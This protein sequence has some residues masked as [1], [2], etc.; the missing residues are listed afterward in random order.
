MTNVYSIREQKLEN[1]DAKHLDKLRAY[2][3]AYQAFP[4]MAKLC[5]VVDMT[6]TASVFALV[7]RLVEAGQLKRVDGRIAPT[8]TFLARPVECAEP[9][10]AEAVTASLEPEVV[11]L[12]DYVMPEP[13]G[14]FFVRVPDEQ[15][16]AKDIRQ[17]DL[18][19]MQADAPVRAGDIVATRQ[20]EKLW[21]NLLTSVNGRK[22][23]LEP[24]SY[25]VQSGRGVSGN[26]T[27][28]DIAGVAIALVR[29]FDRE[30]S[31]KANG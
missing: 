10:H 7:G 19:V 17:G 24:A 6:S 22:L 18:L 8:K 20:A 28:A 26:A 25:D 13:A 5:P 3:E 11:N 29:R 14:T 2:W 9:G 4:S 21:L 12:L 16:A 27:R 30:P 23:V 15:L 1:T 31:K